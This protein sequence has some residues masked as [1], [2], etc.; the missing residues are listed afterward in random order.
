[1]Q[2][3]PNRYLGD[4]LSCAESSK[5]P[6]AMDRD[7]WAFGAGSVNTLIPEKPLQNTQHIFTL[8]VVEFVLEFM[9]QRGSF[10]SLSLNYCGHSISMPSLMS[11]SLWRS[12][13]VCLEEHHYPFDSGLSLAMIKCSWPSG[14]TKKLSIGLSNMHTFTFIS[15]IYAYLNT[16]TAHPLTLVLSSI[17]W[18]WKICS[19]WL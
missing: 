18:G 10:G 11:P 3:D 7:H 14:K 9:L 16:N 5:L 6:D 19:D 17:Y 12:M 15:S 8:E 13:R 4:N 1:M 2:F